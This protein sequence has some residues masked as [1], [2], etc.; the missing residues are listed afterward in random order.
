MSVRFSPRD[1]SIVAGLFCWAL[2]LNLIG[3]SSLEYFRHTEADRTLIG[4]E[5]LEGSSLLVPHLLDTVILTKPPLYYWTLAASFKIFGEVSEFAARF[6]SALLAGLF[7]VLQFLAL[8]RAGFDS[9]WSFLG[10][11]LLS[12]TASFYILAQSAE[13]D[14]MFGFLCALSLYGL[15]FSITSCSFAWIFVAYS[16]LLLASLTKGPPAILFFGASI[17]CFGIWYFFFVV[18]D[19]DQRRR[20]IIYHLLGGFSFCAFLGLWIA[21]LAREVGWPELSAVFDREILSRAFEPS[22]RGRSRAFYLGSYLVSFLPWSLWTIC[23]LTALLLHFRRFKQVV[24]DIDPF[25]AFNL[26]VVITALIILSF[27]EGRSSRYLFPIVPFAV[28]LS[29]FAIQK[30]QDSKLQML[31]LKFFGCLCF[32]ALLTSPALLKLIPFEGAKPIPFILSIFFLLASVAICAFF[33]FR[34]RLPI[35]ILA[36]SFVFLP[37]RVVQAA[38]Y[39]P[40]RNHKR[41][42]IS[43]S[44]SLLKVTA[45]ER[46]LYTLEMFERWIVYYFELAGRKVERLNPEKLDNL[47]QERIL[48]LLSS[49]HERWRLQFLEQSGFFFQIHEELAAG[50]DRVFLVE[51]EAKVMRY[52]KPR[53]ELPTSPSYPFEQSF[54]NR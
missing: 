14:L 40:H 37:V 8:R 22:S 31:L 11:L 15:Y 49:K 6:P 21:L 46:K 26:V 54:K 51:T 43:L 34:G 35:A 17:I 9:W 10:A 36:I 48:L 25:F 33:C 47:G 2:L 7:V 27:A 53:K 4:W 1:F 19:G 30:F 50:R 41:S 5:M 24:K 13:I 23:A 32:L 44:D 29:L 3:I 18:T 20:F 12:T 16:G 42:I 39:A 28:N 45:P 38:I 52:M